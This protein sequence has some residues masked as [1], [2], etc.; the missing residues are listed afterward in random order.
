METKQ[1]LTI[2]VVDDD[3]VGVNVLERTM[4]KEVYQVIKADEGPPVRRLASSQ[5]IYMVE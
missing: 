4:H 1:D 3:P 2:L 5:E